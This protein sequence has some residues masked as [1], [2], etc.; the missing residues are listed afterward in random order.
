MRFE[1]F[2]GHEGGIGVRR[3]DGSLNTGATGIDGAVGYRAICSCGWIGAEDYPP[4]DEGGWAATSEWG[5]HMTPY[6]AATPPDWL[7]NR[8][9]SLRDNLSELAT[10]WPLQ[11]LTVLAAI[12]RWQKP[13]LERAVTAARE[14]G[15]S[16]NEIG[17]ALGITRQSAHERF[18]ATVRRNTN[19]G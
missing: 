6:W 16:W 11:A 15:L 13:I 8:S 12:E 14:T 3:A 19:T 4:A 7:L 5:R 2:P 9:D 1:G 18:S 17:T 10:T